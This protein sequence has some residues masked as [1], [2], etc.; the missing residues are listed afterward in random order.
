MFE[1]KSAWEAYIEKYLD[2]RGS[3]SDAAVRFS[4]VATLLWTLVFLASL[5]R[6][7]R[8]RRNDEDL[9]NRYMEK[10]FPEASDYPRMV[11]GVRRYL[12]AE[13]IITF[14]ILLGTLIFPTMEIHL[15][16]TMLYLFN[17]KVQKDWYNG[18]TLTSFLR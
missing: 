1:K 2:Y 17:R 8:I 11:K 5:R 6:Y 7:M 16:S 10:L 4:Y 12:L 18:G 3:L 9:M 15:L 13:T 14:L